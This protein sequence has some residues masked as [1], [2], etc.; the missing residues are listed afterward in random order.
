MKP[1]Q[2]FPTSQEVGKLISICKTR[3]TV[4]LTMQTLEIGEEKEAEGV[5]RCLFVFVRT[6]QS[7]S[8]Q[9][10]YIITLPELWALF[11]CFDLQSLHCLLL[12][13]L[14]QSLTA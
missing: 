8:V 14:H 2:V 13:S 1:H 10:H 11:Q 12:I 3:T 6:H 7:P 5:L 9:T 4:R